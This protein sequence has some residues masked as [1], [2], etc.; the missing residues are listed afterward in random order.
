M[1]TFTEH[2]GALI[3]TPVD[4]DYETLRISMQ[5]LFQQVGIEAPPAAA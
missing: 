3:W 5:A 4:R 2:A 1:R